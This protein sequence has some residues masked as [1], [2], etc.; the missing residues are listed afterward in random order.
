MK[1]I[2]A[3][4]LAET[5][6]VMGIIGIVATL[7]IPNLNNSTG[8]K[9]TITKVK[10]MYAELNDAQNRAAAKYGPV[11]TW[12]V[13]DNCTTTSSLACQKHYLKRINKFLN[14]QKTCI[15][16]D[17]G[18]FSS[19]SYPSSILS[20]GSSIY[21]SEITDPNCA[22]D[23]FNT[24]TGVLNCG[25]IIIDVDGPNKGKNA[26]GFDLFYLAITKDGI[27]LVYG[28]DYIDGERPKAISECLIHGYACVNWILSKDNMDY[29]YSYNDPYNPKCKDGTDLTWARGS[30]K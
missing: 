28:D 22:R 2:F 16:S 11:P 25:H 15:D 27:G 1:K 9:E 14:V 5:L 10:K 12:F 18:C 7:T 26:Y 23:R 3:F 6:M 30:C 4:T 13:N 19:S 24:G 8:N 29:I 17:G 20:D 21:I